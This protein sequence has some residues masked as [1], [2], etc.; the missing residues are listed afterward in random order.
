MASYQ[1][2]ITVA[3]LYE[4]TDGLNVEILDGKLWRH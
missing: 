1:V 3:I 4:I 2:T